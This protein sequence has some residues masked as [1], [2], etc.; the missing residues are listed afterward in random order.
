[1][2]GIGSWTSSFFIWL[3]LIRRTGIHSSSLLYFDAL[4]LFGPN[5]TYFGNITLIAESISVLL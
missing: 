2:R 5:N 3:D 1:M 4:A